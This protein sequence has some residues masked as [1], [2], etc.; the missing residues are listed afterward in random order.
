[1]AMAALEEITIQRAELERM[2]AFARLMYRLKQLPQYTP[3]IEEKLPATA[4]F[5]PREPSMLMGYDFHLTDE[6]PRLI[7][8]NNNAGGLHIEERGWLPQP[9]IP[10]LAGALVSRLL[11][12]FPPEWQTI[13]I[14]D[15]DIR[16]Q[17]MYQEMQAY[18]EL[19]SAA[20]RRVFLVSPEEISGGAEGLYVGGQRLDAIYNRHT[21]FYLE[22][23]AMYHIREA[24]MA[25]MVHLN[26]FP[27]SYALLGDK[28]RMVDWWHP[29]L[30]EQCLESQEVELVRA[31][32]PETH[33]FG[34][35]DRDQAW[36]E[37]SNWV[38]KPAARHGG[39]GVVLGKGISRKRFD[40]LDEGETVMQQFVPASLVEH[41]GVEYKLDLR[42]YTHG[43]RL[44]ALAARLWRG[45]VTNFREPGSGWACVRVDD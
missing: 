1:M 5:A 29:G 6:G 45:Q 16:Q 9:A 36:Q 3:L 7:E 34:A 41:D 38:F 11:A 2:L 24:F 43:E 18:A 22:T 14:M 23:A 12:M 17:Y 33:L 44:I 39:K 37:R 10:E 4:H 40:S 25:G 20:G 19:L 31:V 30:L 27:R 15:E 13:A 32:V 42:L 21:D 28:A 8:I 35:Y 26:P